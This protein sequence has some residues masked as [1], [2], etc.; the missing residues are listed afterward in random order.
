MLPFL[1]WPGGKRWFASGQCHLL[2]KTFKTYVEPFLG[3]GAVF[4]RIQPQRAVLGDLNED[5]VSVYRVVK[6]DW[7]GVLTELRKH[8][9]LH[10][11]LHYYATR[12]K[13]FTD[14]VK[15]AARLI[16]LNRTC[17]NGIYRVNRQG[18]FNVPK[19]SKDTVLFPEDDFKAVAQLLKKARLLR[20]DF[21]RLIDSA[22]EGDF[23]FADPPY[24]VR[25]NNNSF[26]KYNETLFS[27]HDQIRLADSLAKA[28]QRGVIVVATNANHRSVR[29]L[30]RR[31][32][33]GLQT[34][35][36][37]SSISA[38]TDSRR[39]YDELVITANISETTA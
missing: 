32:G 5:L 8:Q 26:T 23:V 37:F 18:E 20:S 21:A 16:Y 22:S 1:K 39:Q 4:F 38:S 15:Q 27:W 12:Q 10:S 9:R 28:S 24:T 2:P 36:R 11:T 25:H 29:D 13:R 31:S 6:R 30:Y 34:L 35:S 33:F 7:S 17:F 14:P 3:S 19:G